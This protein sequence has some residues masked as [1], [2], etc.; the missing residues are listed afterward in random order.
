MATATHSQPAGAPTAP[1]SEEGEPDAPKNNI[2]RAAGIAVMIGLAMAWGLAF[3][4]WGKRDSPDLI[5]QS[6]YAK[7]AE[8]ICASTIDKID[9]LPKAE[10]SHTPEERSVIVGRANALL[11][12]MLD[13]LDAMTVTSASDR[14]VH[15][16]WLA[17]WRA[18]LSDRVRYEKRLA[19]GDPGPF[20]ESARDRK[21]ISNY[22]DQFAETNQLDS[23]VTPGDV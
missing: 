11:A 10:T 18:H 23:C 1:I 8:S 21:Q 9:A 16:A 2:A 3:A 14:K 12:T 19:S 17:D 22:V 5:K 15:D 6:G 7:T 20:T 4:G 13:D